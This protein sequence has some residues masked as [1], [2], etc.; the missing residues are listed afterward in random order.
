MW[1]TGKSQPNVST[2]NAVDGREGQCRH[3]S[4]RGE[5]GG[6][7]IRQQYDHVILE[8]DGYFATPTSATLAF[9]PLTPCPVADTRYNN[10]PQASASRTCRAAWLATFRS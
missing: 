10:Y 8:L 3:H 4:G 7:R 2:L 5:P 9:Y 6:Q 1:P